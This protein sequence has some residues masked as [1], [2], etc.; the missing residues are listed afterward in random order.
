MVKLKLCQEVGINPENALCLKTKVFLV[1][2]YPQRF[3]KK[4]ILLH[5]LREEPKVFQI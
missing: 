3:K 4:K 1:Y 5:S 2:I